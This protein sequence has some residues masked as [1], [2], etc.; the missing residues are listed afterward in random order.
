VRYRGNNDQIQSAYN[1]I[2]ELANRPASRERSINK[3]RGRSTG[4]RSKGKNIPPRAVLDGC[5]VRVADTSKISL[6]SVVNS[7]ASS[8]SVISS[9]SSEIMSSK[10]GRR[11]DQSSENDQASPCRKPCTDRTVPPT[12]VKEYSLFDNLFSRTVEQVLSR[13]DS[14]SSVLSS[15]SSIYPMTSLFV[16]SYARQPSAAVDQALLAKAPGYR[17]SPPAAPVNQFS[18][19]P[20]LPFHLASDI[21]VLAV[22]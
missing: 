9:H 2:T 13:R 22:V 5:Q 3:H 21:L 4:C 7:V 17:S 16:H 10:P 18:T 8:S 11:A 14:P 19:V 1:L 15:R 20:D 12:P 6:D